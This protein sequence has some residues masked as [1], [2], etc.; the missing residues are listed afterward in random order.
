VKLFAAVFV[1]KTKISRDFFAFPLFVLA[2]LAPLCP[3]LSAQDA[4]V[5]Q[6]AQTHPVFTVEAASKL[7]AQ[8][9]K[10]LQGHSERTMLGAFDL[11]LMEQ[12]PIFKQQITALFEQ[13]DDIRVR[14]KLEEIKDNVALVDAEIDQTPRNDADPPRHK[15][16][17]L[18]FTGAETA[19]GWK[20][21]D[22]QPR[23]FFSE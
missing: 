1:K 4:S 14:F 9:A 19:D 22:V 7:L 3:L 12:G 8:V 13:Y 2:L 18:R 5:A 11:S 20:F 15:T 6:A 21:I 16:A 23:S 17:E 10:G